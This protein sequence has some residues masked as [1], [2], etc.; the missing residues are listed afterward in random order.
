MHKSVK[1]IGIKLTIVVEEEPKYVTTVRDPTTK[2]GFFGGLEKYQ[3]ELMAG[4]AILTGKVI[5]CRGPKKIK[6]ASRPRGGKQRKD[7]ENFKALVKVSG[8][9]P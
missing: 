5:S 3:E 4:R 1:K 9:R 8:A 7:E 2:E 6:K